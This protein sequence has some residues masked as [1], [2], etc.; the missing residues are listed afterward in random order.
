VQVAA[1]L[2]DKLSTLKLSYAHNLTSAST[3]GAE[4]ARKLSSTD[5]TFALAYAKKLT[6]GCL[7]KA[8]IDNSGLLSLLYE[9][10]LAGGE[11]VAGSFQLQTTDF[12]KPVKYGFSLDLA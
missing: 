11:K 4:V 12:T 5:T 2:T 10:K 9:T 6:S 8:K 7:T 1:F 3:V